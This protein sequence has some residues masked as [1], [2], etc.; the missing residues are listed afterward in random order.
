MKAIKLNYK[1]YSILG[2]NKPSEKDGKLLI[3]WNPR[4]DVWKY[5]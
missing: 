2:D 1:D 3:L 4:N 5:V